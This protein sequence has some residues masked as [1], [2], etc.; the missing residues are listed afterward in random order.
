MIWE[1]REWDDAALLDWDQKPEEELQ[2]KNFSHGIR[3][4]TLVTI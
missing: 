3:S 4:V 1:M 2:V